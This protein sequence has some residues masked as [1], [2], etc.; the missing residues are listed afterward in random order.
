MQLDDLGTRFEQLE[1]TRSRIKMYEIL[2]MLVKETRPAEMAIVAYLCEGRLL[3]A[4]TGLEIGVGERLVVSAIASA[5]GGTDQE[6]QRL[7]KRTG[8]L[9]DVAERLA[10]RR[11]SNLT[12]TQM[13]RSLLSIARI[14]GVDS[15]RRKTATLAA[16]L[17]QASPRGARY[18]VRFVLGRL[19]L[20]V[21]I[22]TLI[23]A[24]A[25][26]T[27]DS[28][29]ARATIER[30]YHLRSDIGLVLRTFK[31]G[32]IRDLARFEVTPGNPVSMMLAERLPDVEA[33]IKRLGR[34][35]AESKI[36]GFR[37]QVHVDN[38]RVEIFSRNL[39]RTTPMFPDIVRAI[40][41]RLHAKNAIIEGEA[42]AFNESTGEF[43]PFQVT[44]QRKRKYQVEEM[45]REFPLALIAFEVLY[46][47]GKDY[48]RT[49]YKQRRT[50]LERY[51][52]PDMH[53]RLVDRIVTAKPEKLQEFFDHQLEKGLEGIVAKKLDAPY[54][55]GARNFNWVKLKRTYSGSLS[56]TIDVVI[57]G[58]LRGRGNR[59]RLGIGAL[60]GAVYDPPTDSFQSIAKIGSG[61]SE[62][63]WI[64]IRRL[65]DDARVRGK[66]ARV[67]SRLVPD[68]WVAPRYVVTVLA[69]EITR[70]PV[71]TCASDDSGRGL[72]LRFPRVVGFIRS[73]KSPEDAT[74]ATEI[75]KMA[76]RQ[77][78]VRL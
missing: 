57:I 1:H 46:A 41:K 64:R 36:D 50:A 40:R 49:A 38:S 55:P 17:L 67:N 74:T 11:T 21:G 61:L 53:I 5:F 73:D 13:Y 76:I 2:G 10:R 47:D 52:R 39:E 48:T 44:V 28:R 8:D 54:E 65:L 70:S 14:S 7:F 32:G 51:L 43:Y 42:V 69:D 66:P 24:A 60:L 37:C 62:E 15:V 12:V 9:G 33:I 31:K 30:A 35:A 71:H 72:A 27:E 26:T 75:Q 63:N 59:A 34:C 77:K 6:I 19:R 78:R 23:E 45:A 56:D 68:V 4:Y 29:N 58:Y 16:L 25:R 22:T 20:G 3:P 18:I